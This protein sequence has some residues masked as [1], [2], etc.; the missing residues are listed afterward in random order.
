[1]LEITPLTATVVIASTVVAG[2]VIIKIVK[3]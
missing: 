3:K 2:A 1:M